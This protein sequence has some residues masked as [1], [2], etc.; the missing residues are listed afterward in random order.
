MLRM[1]VNNLGPI[2]EAD[3]E[4][5]PLTVL[6]GAS[7]SGKSYF[8]TLLHSIGL[9]LGRFGSMSQT[10]NMLSGGYETQENYLGAEKFEDIQTIIGWLADAAKPVNNTGSSK[11]VPVPREIMRKVSKLT[12][13]GKALNEIVNNTLDKHICPEN[14][15]KDSPLSIPDNGNFSISKKV[16]NGPS[17]DLQKVLTVT[18]QAKEGK[19]LSDMH[20]PND[21][22]FG[23]LSYRQ[24]SNI[25]L[26]FTELHDVVNQ[27]AKHF[28]ESGLPRD[29]V[30]E[31]ARALSFIVTL[32]QKHVFE[33]FDRPVHF[34]PASRSVLLY[35]KGFYSSEILK[36]LSIL[37]GH[38]KKVLDPVSAIY[39]SNIERFSG[40]HSHQDEE[41]VD[42]AKDLESKILGGEIIFREDAFGNSFYFFRPEGTKNDMDLSKTSSMVSDLAPL[43]IHLKGFLSKGD[44]I[45]IEEPESHLH[46][47]MQV[48]IVD[49][50]AR[51]VNY[52]IRVVMTTHSEWVVERLAH[53]VLLSKL[54]KQ[55][56][57]GISGAKN[58]LNED[59]VGVWE[60]KTSK[61]KLTSVV[62]ESKPNFGSGLYNLGFF[63]VAT[64][65]HNEYARLRRRVE[66]KNGDH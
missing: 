26:K 42:L 66:K 64:E 28:T 14:L 36:E 11:S 47:R 16:K 39:L 54:D 30:V 24:I 46:P 29:A 13:H 31:L 41:L 50:L 38:E 45:I 65:S 2:C 21:L 62:S 19:Y 61:K 23:H 6:A 56:R 3:V 35:H 22:T 49:L 27:N 25:A 51:L 60:F 5:R 12:G 37:E 17:N 40:F 20:F 4:L 1:Q 58:P 8:S 48:E 63:K 53:L 52:G 43:V 9:I 34:L 55:D 57:K 15:F 7:N 33:D 18:Y 10:W 59:E 44:T 32:F